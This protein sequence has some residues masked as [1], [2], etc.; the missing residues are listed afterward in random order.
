MQLPR[1]ALGTVQASADS[2]LVCWALMELLARSGRRVQ[3]FHSR[4]CFHPLDAAAT[5]TGRASRHLDTWVMTPD[6]AL[7]CF[8]RGAAD[9]G[10]ACVEGQFDVARGDTSGGSL[11]MLCDWLDLPR[12]AA[13]D[14]RL[15][16]SQRPPDRPQADGLLLD[17][18][19][20][21]ADFCR[22]QSTFESRWNIPV[23]GGL[24]DAPALRQR[25]DS[26]PC[27][28]LLPRSVGDKLGNLAAQYMQLDAI[29][30]R[31]ERR[32]PLVAEDP[33]ARL[34]AERSSRRLRIA[35]AYDEAFHGYFCDVLELL[36]AID[37]QIVEFSPLHDEQ[38]PADSDIV[39][40]GCGRPDRFAA[41]LS[42]N[43]CM[44][45]ALRT[46]VCDGRRLFADGGGLAYLS[47]FLQGEAGRWWPM[48][49][50]V[51][52][53]AHL[54]GLFRP[55]AAAELTLARRCWLGEPG[56]RLRGYLNPRWRLEPRREIESLAG[57]PEHALDLVASDQAI[58][59][60]MHLNFAAHP[61]AL[62]HLLAV[63]AT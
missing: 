62:E 29:C 46:H 25:I 57:E 10:F 44:H 52:A 45:A 51:P 23:L 26:L 20:D 48:V 8:L 36:E 27:G 60:R 59:S 56:T 34:A 2:R 53:N 9:G 14:V 11:D 4:C 18:V 50:I 63:P 7:A 30:A 49:G 17:G 28:S 37:A 31:A 16:D 13:I 35:V 38:L 33:V 40:I 43:H 22:W 15:I 55:P 32:A 19:R 58:V 24:E 5:V 54:A 6:V 1:V 42:E 61:Q 47:E 21:Q 3:H 12:L 39:Y 41:D